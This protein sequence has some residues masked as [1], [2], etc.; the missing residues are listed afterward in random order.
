M[1]V[2]YTQTSR[3]MKVSTP[4]GPDKLL[5]TGFTGHEMISGLYSF[6]LDLITENTTVVDF[7]ALLGKELAVTMLIDAGT[8]GVSSKERYFRGICRRIVQGDR[9]DSF[10]TFRAEIVPPLWLTTRVARSRVFQHLS[11][12]DI[13]KKVL[14]G[15]QVKWMV[16]GTFEKRDYCVQYRETDFNFCARLMEEEGIF[17]FFK[18]NKDNLEMVVANTPSAHEEVE[19]AAKLVYDVVTGSHRRARHILEW[20]KAQEVRSGKYTLW[21]H[22][23]ELPG[24]NLEAKKNTLATVQIGKV[25]HN[26]QVGGNEAFEIYNYPGE[27]TQRFDG[28]DTGGGEQASSRQ[29]STPTMPARLPCAWRRKRLLAS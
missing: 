14:S 27:Y 23:F 22:C 19:G 15:L 21:D 29:K 28:I 18:H 20:E 9:D 6:T 8:D 5:L 4:L 2:T 12:P 17:Y 10:T 16:Q 13:L 3:N 11:V 24:N 7:G 26:L 1:P 25:N